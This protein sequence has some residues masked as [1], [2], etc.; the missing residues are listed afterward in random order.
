VHRKCAFSLRL[1]AGFFYLEGMKIGPATNLTTSLQLERCPHC[2]I[3]RPQ[4]VEKHHLNTNDHE[5]KNPR[6]WRVY[7]CT[8]C[9]G[10]VTAYSYKPNE[11]VL[12]FYPKIRRIEE[13]LPPKVKKYM[14][15]AIQSIHAPS[16]AIMLC[17][18]AVDAMLKEKGLISDT[19]YK[20]IDKATKDHIITEG[21]AE[22]A[23]Q[24]RLDANDQRHADV[25]ASDA[26]EVD[27]K[28]AI[29]FTE[30]LAE[31]MF[32][33]PARVKRGL[34]SATTTSTLPPTANGNG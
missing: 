1:L 11:A 16:G 15:Q 5:G 4:L 13:N 10:V 8:N 19:L 12:G 17:A 3:A 24:V 28:N 23:H 2:T 20:R 18:S 26:T 34:E 7:V 21:M 32:V 27:A 31:L 25:D 6:F 22:W 33:L 9:G 14:E 29:D 30:A